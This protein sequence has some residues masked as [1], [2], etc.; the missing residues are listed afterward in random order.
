LDSVVGPWNAEAQRRSV[1]SLDPPEASSLDAL[2]G[3]DIYV[4]QLTP[5]LRAMG[6]AAIS[7]ACCREGAQA[8]LRALLAAHQRAMLAYEHG[9]HHSQSDSLVAARAAL[10]QAIDN[11]DEVTLE[12][13]QNY[14]AN[15]RV[16]AEGLRALAAAAEERAEVGQHA[17]RLWPNIMDL[18]LDAAEANPE[19]FTDRTWGDEAEAALMPNPA[20]EG[21]YLTIELAGQPYRWRDPLTWEPQVDRWL[22]AI[23]RTRMSIDHFVIAVRDL[24]VADQNEQGLRWIERIVVESGS[25]CASTFTLP[26]WLHERRADLTTEDQIARWQR[27]VDLLVVAGDS[28]VADLAD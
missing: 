4:Q 24:D 9:Y 14:V 1:V 8:A 19:L 27:V 7:C 11:R 25:N 2:N 23:T 5:A 26:E 3:D 22:G 13:V 17:N 16:L 6:A 18:V 20:A 15:A 10:W 21:R 28:R 12:Y